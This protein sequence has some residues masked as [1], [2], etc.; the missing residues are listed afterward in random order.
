MPTPGAPPVIAPPL[1]F[2][3]IVTCDALYTTCRNSDNAPNFLC[4]NAHGDC[5]CG[6]ASVC[7]CANAHGDCYCEQATDCACNNIH[8]DCNGQRA[9][10]VT[11][12]ALS[13]RCCYRSSGTTVITTWDNRYEREVTAD[14]TCQGWRFFYYSTWWFWILAAAIIMSF[15]V[16]VNQRRRLADSHRGR[17]TQ[18][19]AGPALIECQPPIAPITGRPC[20][21]GY[22]SDSYP[23]ASIVYATATPIATANA[24][25]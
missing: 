10:R 6:S 1:P 11:C 21:S 18:H 23:T 17:L 2:L 3:P 22:P 13:G 12:N 14:G 7:N 24:R 5:H 19:G 9:Q 8:G 4:N 20:P 25:S 16:S 15:S